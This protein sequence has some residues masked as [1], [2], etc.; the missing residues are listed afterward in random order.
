[1]L[2][3]NVKFEEI[4]YDIDQLKPVLNEIICILLY[5]TKNKCM[6]NQKTCSF[7]GYAGELKILQEYC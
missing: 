7:I 4:V 3:K 1:M 5:S 6:S 2:T